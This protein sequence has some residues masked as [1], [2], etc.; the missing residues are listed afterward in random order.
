LDYIQWLFG[1]IKIEYC[2]SKKLSNLDI[3]TDDFLNL[4]GKTKKVSSLQLTLNYFTRT[5]T[6]QI[7]IDGKNISIQADLIKKQVMYYEDKKKRIYNFANSNRNFEYKEQH[8]AILS[9]K[10]KDKLCTFEEGKQIV[11]LI[12]KIRSKTK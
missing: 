11:Y 5:P 8:L 10:F 7:Y 6:R 4:V 1:N 2:K 3:E 9:N 12:N